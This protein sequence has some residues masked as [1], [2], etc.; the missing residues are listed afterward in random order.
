[1]LRLWTIRLTILLMSTTGSVTLAQEISEELRHHC[2][3]VTL[4]HPLHFLA[5]DGSDAVVAPGYYQ[6]EAVDKTHVRLVPTEGT[7]PVVI[8]ATEITHKEELQAS[9][10][11]STPEDADR[12]HVVLLMPNGLGMDAMGSANGVQPRAL[13]LPIWRPSFELIRLGVV[14]MNGLIATDL[15]VQIQNWH[16]S[17]HTKVSQPAPMWVTLQGQTVDLSQSITNLQSLYRTTNNQK[18]GAI[19]AKMASQAGQMRTAI[20]AYG[21][22]KQVTTLQSDLRAIDT[23][24]KQIQMNVGYLKQG[25]SSPQPPTLR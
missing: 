9:L 5:K 13:R 3:T 17:Q 22:A 8:Q 2:V 18:S 7:G 23:H 24:L 6:V 12:H 4:D 14:N 20:A 11:L 19:A 25:L 21:Q 15:V 1:M 16:Q 10:A